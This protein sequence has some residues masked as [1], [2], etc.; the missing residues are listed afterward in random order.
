VVWYE[1]HGGGHRW[2]PHQEGVNEAIAEQ[3]NGVSS[4]NFN[5]SENIWKFFERHPRR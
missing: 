2:P 3:E 5:A 1:I 4:Q